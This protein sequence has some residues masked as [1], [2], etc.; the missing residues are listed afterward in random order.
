MA[1]AWQRHLRKFA[2]APMTC[3]PRRRLQL[4]HVQVQAH[5]T[6]RECQRKGGTWVRLKPLLCDPNPE[7]FCFSLRSVRCRYMVLD[8]NVWKHTLITSEAAAAVFLAERP[9]YSAELYATSRKMASSDSMCLHTSGD[10]NSKV[11]ILGARDDNSKLLPCN[12]HVHG[13]HLSNMPE[14]R[15]K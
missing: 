7:W 11:E 14:N 13:P 8:H 15:M 12:D 5:L 9:V 4:A 2:L 10:T 6:A 3:R 1:L